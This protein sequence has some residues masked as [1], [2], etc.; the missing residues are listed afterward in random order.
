MADQRMILRSIGARLAFVGL[1]SSLCGGSVLAEDDDGEQIEEVVVTGSYLKGSPTD[2]PSPVKVVDREQ[3]DLEGAFTL[4]DVIRNLTVN[5]GSLGNNESSAAS[6]AN[7]LVGVQNVNLRGLGPNSTLVLVNGKRLA[8]LAAQTTS[9]GEV[10]DT[11]NIPSIMTERFEVLL[12]GGSAL[13][14]SDAVAGVFNI[15]MRTE[16]EGLEIEGQTGGMTEATDRLNERAAGIWGW[17]SDD[18]D[19]HFVISGEHYHQD[20]VGVDKANFFDEDIEQF[21]GTVGTWPSPTLGFDGT[22]LNPAWVNQPLI[23]QAI[24]EGGHGGTRVTDPLCYELTDSGGDPF[25]VGTQYTA[26]GYPDS[27]CREDTSE[28]RQITTEYERNSIAGSLSHV[29]NDKLEF[30]SFFNYSES[31][32]VWAHDGTTGSPYPHFTLAPPGAFGGNEMSSGLELGFFAPY[33]VR[34]GREP[35]E[36]PTF[37]SNHPGA[38]DNGG[39]N[40]AM[41]NY[42]QIGAPRKRS[43]QN[44]NEQ[45]ASVVQLGLKGDFDFADRNLN[46]DVGLSWSENSLEASGLHMNRER[47]ELA[48]NGLGGANC[49]PNG[50]EDFDFQTPRYAWGG[51][52]AYDYLP[53]ITTGSSEQNVNNLHRNMSL[54]LTSNNHGVGDCQF[55]NPYLTAQPG[56]NPDLANSAELIDWMT[57]D[58]L[59]TDKRNQLAVFDAVVSGELF[60]MAGGTAQFAMGMQYREETR[61]SNA[62]SLLDPFG[63]G[64]TNAI[65]SFNDD[66]PIYNDEGVMIRES[67]TVNETHEFISNSLTCDRCSYTF[68]LKRKVGSVFGELSLP[69]W[70]NFESQVALRYEKYNGG[71]GSKVTPKI[72]VSYRPIDELLVRGSFSKSFRAPNAGVVENGLG[73]Y[74]AS[75]QDPFR[76]QAVRAGILDPRDTENHRYQSAYFVGAP[77]PELGPEEA[78]TYSFGFQWKPQDFLGLDVEGFDIGM[79]YWRFEYSDRV[80]PQPAAEAFNDEIEAFLIAAADPDNY[81][82]NHTQQPFGL[83]DARAEFKTPCDPIALSAEYG[84]GLPAD[85][86]ADIA[87]PLAATPVPP[88]P[89]IEEFPRLNCVVDQ[90]TYAV[91]SVLRAGGTSAMYAGIRS[92]S[93]KSIN[94][95]E[96]TTDGIDLA[97]N[98]RFDTDWGLFGVGLEYTHINQYTLKNIPGFENGFYGTGVFDAAGTTGGDGLTR[99][100]PDN[101]GHINFWWYLPQH[102]LSFTNRFIGSYT[103]LVADFIRDNNVPEV[104]ARVRDSIPSYDSWDFHYQYRHEF[105]SSSSLS[106]AVFSFNMMDMFNSPLPYRELGNSGLRYDA[107]AP[108]DPRGRRFSLVAR[109]MF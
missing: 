105:N 97:M 9:G 32:A 49:V 102:T 72:A 31:E 60:E 95:G 70:E 47:T 77:S 48:A 52:N 17:R 45:R 46:F 98:Y 43:V 35:L 64:V 75:V 86:L 30:Y 63:E 40:V 84:D 65:K 27:M 104:A 67:G 101:R 15:I 12:D 41:D 109:F 103:D 37:I 38:T 22:D 92:I 13:Y 79:T 94:A 88:S 107:Q 87:F 53:H 5:S 50:V 42:L 11:G 71:I 58:V 39:P 14:G 36:A 74:G 20:E 89:N 2:A 29:F 85:P 51:W 6:P 8:P 44:S 91:D 23:D 108:I 1:A 7:D 16:F 33:V 100:L 19:T 18:E 73:S 57:Q 83:D 82:L 4:N 21:T 78:D 54:A 56:G 69:V 24:A 10:V 96:I 25:F 81:I 68:N 61:D 66:G 106:S 62:G 90:D 59:L 3:F 93:A 76:A 26:E 55:F 80:S 28:F 99:S 34:E